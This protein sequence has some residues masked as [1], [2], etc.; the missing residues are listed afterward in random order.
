MNCIELVETKEDIIRRFAYQH[1]LKRKRLNL[2]LN[3][4][5]D[6]ENAGLDYEHYEKLHN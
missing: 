3:E 1:Y 4:K 5:E 2:P 6:W